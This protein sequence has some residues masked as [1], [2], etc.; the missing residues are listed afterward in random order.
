MYDNFRQILFL[1]PPIFLLAG[2]ALDAAFQFLRKW[3]LRSFLLLILALPG[4]YWCLN[5]HPYEYIYYNSLVGNLQ[6]AKNKFELDYWMTSFRATTLFLDQAAQPNEKVL[7]WGP[8]YLVNPYARPDLTIES[9]SSASAS[10]TGRYAYAVLSSRYGQ[11]KLYPDT[12]PIFI[13][14]RAGA[15]LAVVKHL[16]SF[17]SP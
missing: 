15:I 9:E 1:T 14:S 3:W 6:G 17:S 8:D 16:T 4:I 13:V 11:Y 5:L 2:I 12:V 10:L 7:V